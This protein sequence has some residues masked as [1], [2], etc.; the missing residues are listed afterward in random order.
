VPV[1]GLFFSWLL[2]GEIPTSLT[3]L[4]GLIAL[5]GIVMVNQSKQRTT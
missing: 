2:L 3:L 1:F 4:G 5:V